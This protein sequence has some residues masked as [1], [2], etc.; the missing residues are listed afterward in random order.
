MNTDE[1]KLV[2]SRNMGEIELTQGKLQQITGTLV[3]R[4]AFLGDSCLRRNDGGA[5][6]TMMPARPACGLFIAGGEP[7][8]K[9]Q[10]D[11]A[12]DPVSPE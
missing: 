9:A 10:A 6:G 7:A 11:T 3:R 4:K 2:A 12:G 8:E 1:G 5:S